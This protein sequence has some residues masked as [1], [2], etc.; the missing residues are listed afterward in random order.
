MDIEEWQALDPRVQHFIV[1]N[2]HRTLLGLAVLGHPLCAIADLSTL[3][4]DQ[5]SDRLTHSMINIRGSGQKVL[6]RL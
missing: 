6:V 1:D 3:V 4:L 5:C 2:E